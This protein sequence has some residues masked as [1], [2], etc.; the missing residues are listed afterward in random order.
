MTF[1]KKL[2]DRALNVAP[3]STLAIAAKVNSLKTHG[4]DIIG[5]GAGEPDFDTPSHI[6]DAAIRAL[7]AGDTKYT[8][9][10]G[11]N[12]LKDAIIDKLKNDNG[13]KY[14]RN[15][16]IVSCGSKQS[17]YNAMQ[18]ILNP[19]D[20][21]IIPSPYWVS[22]PE[23]VKLTGAKPVFINSGLTDQFII[24][25]SLLEKHITS[26]TKLVIINSPANPTG[27][28]YSQQD[29]HD[30]SDLLVSKGIYLLSDEIYEKIIYRNNR[31]V[32][33]ASFSDEAKRLTI[34]V[35]G[36][37]KTY[38]MTGWRIGYAAGDAEIISAMAR[39]QD[40][41][42]SNP[43]SFAQA[44]A[45]EALRGPQDAVETMRRSF[46]E[47]RDRIVSL[48]NNIPG[49]NCPNPGGAFYVFPNIKSLYGKKWKNS[50]SEELVINGSQAFA[51]YL[52]SKVQVAV[53]P[54]IGFGADDHIRLSYTLPME[55]IEIGIRRI[56]DA[57]VA[58]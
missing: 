58:L 36:F 44:G 40:Q 30:I 24:S 42:T 56:Y 22:Y 48:L 17:I 41:S 8:P 18:A 1:D 20:E 57:V 39:I 4:V 11:T 52:L 27:C 15:E 3:S 38:A 49:I 21:V 9:S 10:S 46:E 25:A 50:I 5:F 55:K 16:V 43:T 35:N 28:V 26:H 2:S 31:F 7:I 32:S 33:P 6:K 23:Q 53:V 45:V 19:G 12:A 37:S 13:I 14:G 29:L 51:E 54:G 34:T 47:R